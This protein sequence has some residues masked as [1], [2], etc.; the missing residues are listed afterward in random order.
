VADYVT[1]VLEITEAGVPVRTQGQHVVRV[2]GALK[3][4]AIRA[5]SGAK[6]NMGTDTSA[7]LAYVTGQLAPP[8][9]DVGAPDE[10][11]SVPDA[12]VTASGAIEFLKR[13]GVA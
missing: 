12:V 3:Q 4:V 9:P 10:P 6:E 2:L 1:S 7:Y 13:G 11:F 5:R 8:P